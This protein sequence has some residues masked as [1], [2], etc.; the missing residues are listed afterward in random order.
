MDCPRVFFSRRR[1]RRAFISLMES[2]FKGRG[3]VDWIFYL[4][5][6]NCPFSVLMKGNE[7]ILIIFSVKYGRVT[8]WLF[9][10]VYISVVF[11]D[12]N[13]VA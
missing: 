8:S 1:C 13:R 12:D 2:E 11:T 7:C 10:I 5:Y 3:W 6:F 9:L 4:S